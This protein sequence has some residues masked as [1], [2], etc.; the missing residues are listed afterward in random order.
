LTAY[1]QAV[2]KKVKLHRDC[3]VV[4]CNA[5][6]SAPY[7][8]IGRQMLVSGGLRQVR[9]YTTDYQLVATHDR[10]RTPG[11]R[12]THPDHLPPYKLPALTLTRPI[13]LTRAEKIGPYT[14]KIVAT[15]LEDP[16]LDRLQTCGRLIR[17]GDTHG[18]DR[19]E[20]A[21][22]RAVC[23]DDLNYVTIKRILRQGL[24]KQPL[25]DIVLPPPATAF[26]RSADELVG[27]LQGGATWR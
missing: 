13:A 18:H 27:H 12:K 10:A 9:I 23:F 8:Y 1:E 16:V 7:R 11:E 17:L 24:E 26:V 3:H 22:A 6:Y 5:Y 2:W 25:P 21:C 4:F 19:L 15:W 20:A 14:Q